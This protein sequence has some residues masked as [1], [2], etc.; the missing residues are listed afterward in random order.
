VKLIEY[1][2]LY[3]EDLLRKQYNTRSL[4]QGVTLARQVA[5][6]TDTCWV[7][8]DDKA[9]PLTDQARGAVIQQ[10]NGLFEELGLVPQHL[11]FEKAF[12]E[13]APQLIDALPQHRLRWESFRKS[14]KQVLFYTG[15][16]VTIPLAQRAITDHDENKI[17]HYS[18]PLLAS[19]WR[20][21][22]QQHCEAS[23]TILEEKYQHVEI[24]VNYLLKDS[25]YKETNL[26]SFIWH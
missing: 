7:L 16:G 5:G 22:K 1:G 14:N 24:Q 19:L 6:S 12:A 13:Q 2:H 3:V 23:V 17:I 8:L 21:Y 4:Q 18:C 15:S 20:K 10:A 11:H 26:H 25:G 9:L